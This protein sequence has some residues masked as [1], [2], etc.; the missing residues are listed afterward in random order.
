M[1]D[2]V[3]QAVNEAVNENAARTETPH[4]PHHQVPTGRYLALLSL[5]ALGVVYGDIGTSPLYAL[6]EVFHGPYAI[7]ANVTNVFG[8][9][10]LIFWALMLVITVKYLIFV[11]QADNRGEGGILALTALATPIK[12][13]GAAERRWLVILGLFGAALLYG[14]GMITPAISVLSATEGLGIVTPFFEPYIVPLTI[15]ILIGLFLLQSRGTGSVGRVFGPIMLTWFTTLGLLGLVHIVGHLEILTSLNPVYAVQ[16]FRANGLIGFLVLGTVVLV[17]TGGEALYADMGHFGRRPIRLAWFTVALPGLLLNYYGQGAL[18]LSEPEAAVNPFYLLAPA[19]ALVPLVGLATCATVIAS[20]ALISG[21]FSITTQAVQL[22]FLPRLQITH[23]SST[24]YGQIYIPALNWMLMFGCIAI[25]IGFRTSSNLAAAYG[26]ATTSAMTITTVV[27]YIVARERWQWSRWQAAALSSLFMVVDLAFLGAN[28]LKIPQGGWF[29]L[30]VA[31]IIFTIMTTWKHGRRLVWERLYDE[32][33][34]VD[35]VLAA[36][37]SWPPTRVPGVAVYMSADPSVVPTALLVNID[38][39]NVLHETILLTTIAIEEVAHVRPQNRLR[40]EPLAHGVYQLK[41]RY[42]FMEQPDV[43]KALQE[44]SIPGVVLD[45]NKF[46]YFV[47]Q[48]RAIPSKVPGMAVW[49]EK[50][51]AIMLRNAADASEYFN[52]P[53]HQVIEVGRRVEV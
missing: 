13:L 33:R 28:L 22:G 42:G 37:N 21:A 18:L 52:I 51:F 20:Q 35:R 6:R 43:P 36:A 50:L 17:V 5:G 12:V 32:Q 8:V 10:S 48:T 38:H 11:L 26:I 30:V 1:A 24:E 16:F 44:L 7:A 2:I 53:P 47:D 27:F 23:T 3:N 31:A 4:S 45:P 14:D 34:Q 29:P 25:V 15:A 40:L 9:L 19:W 46:T 49:R 41:V 39:N